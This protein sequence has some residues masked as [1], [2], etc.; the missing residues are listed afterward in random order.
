MT[1]KWYNDFTHLGIFT[2]YFL[3]AISHRGLRNDFFFSLS[4]DLLSIF[5]LDFHFPL[6]FG[7]LSP[8]YNWNFTSLF[9][10]DFNLYSFF[11]SFF[12][13]SIFFWYFQSGSDFGFLPI[14]FF[15]NLPPIFLNTWQ[16]PLESQAP[17]ELM[18]KMPQWHHLQ[19]LVVTILLFIPKV[20]KPLNVPKTLIIC[21]MV[22]PYWWVSS[23]PFDFAFCLT[24]LY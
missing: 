5:Y 23:T 16:V 10:L 2:L 12:D 4:A 18:V 15:S 20:V 3:T 6:L 24:V 21:G 9:Y 14:F 22:T 7:F 8:F 19:N 13:L 17:M 11:Q 1:E